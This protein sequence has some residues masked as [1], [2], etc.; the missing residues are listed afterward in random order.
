MTLLVLIA[1]CFPIVFAFGEVGVSTMEY[2]NFR[3][4]STPLET[5]RDT[6]T[7]GEVRANRNKQ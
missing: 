3:A 7:A 4:W 6:T 5:S 1:P 2:S